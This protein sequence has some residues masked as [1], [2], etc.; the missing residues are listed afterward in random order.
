MLTPL[1]PNLA[2]RLI[3]LSPQPGDPVR[4]TLNLACSRPDTFAGRYRLCSQLELVRGSE[5]WRTPERKIATRTKVGV[6][7]VVKV[8]FSSTALECLDQPAP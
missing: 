5:I 3:R 1:H 4:L 6:V 2:G 8:Q 7:I